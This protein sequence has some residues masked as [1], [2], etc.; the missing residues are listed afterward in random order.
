MSL[1]PA[2]NRAQRSRRSRSVLAALALLGASGAALLPTAPAAAAGGNT[3]VSCTI[4]NSVSCQVSDPDG[5]A[6]VRVTMDW[7]G[8]TVDLVDESFAC[9]TQVAVS[10]DS[11]Y[12]ADEILV[13]DCA[14]PP[15]GGG[16]GSLTIGPAPGHPSAPSALASSSGGSTQVTYSI[17]GVFVVTPKGNWYC[18]EDEEGQQ[19]VCEPAG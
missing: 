11:A 4:P 2:S 10:W 3:T 6:S 13:E 15:V 12:H 9:Q 17:P 5:I 14:G 16:R 19:S 18:Y 1:S 7:K 8:T